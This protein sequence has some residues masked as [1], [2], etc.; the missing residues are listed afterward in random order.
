VICLQ[1]PADLSWPLI[2]MLNPDY[3]LVIV[4]LVLQLAL[5]AILIRGKHYKHFPFFSVYTAFAVA[6]GGLLLGAMSFPV[7]FFPLYW[8]TEATSGVLELLALHEAFKPSL[9][10]YYKLYR[11]TR[12]VP[13]LIV[14]LIVGNALWR[15][16]YYPVG[17]GSFVHLAA[18]AYAF[19]VGVRVLEVGIFL[20]ALKLA[21]RKDHPI[22]QQ[23]PFGIVIGFGFAASTALLADFVGLKFAFKFG[24]VFDT[25]FRYMPASGYIAAAA[26]WLIAFATGDRR[27]TRATPEEIQRR[28]DQQGNIR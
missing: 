19:E 22:G 21:R 24:H 15:G 16:G 20:L 5:L 2:F 1:W 8:I 25:I 27:R 12:G 17:H 26:A 4:G 11:W 23:Y 10:M 13:L 14:A 3:A 18:G 28:L 6:A 7:L 9:E